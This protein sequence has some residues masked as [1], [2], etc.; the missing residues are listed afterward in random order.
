MQVPNNKRKIANR[1]LIVMVIGL[2]MIFLPMNLGLDG[3]DG[4]FALAV[5]GGLIAI[6]ALI[7][8][9]IYMRLA[10]EQDQLMSGANVLAHWKYTAEQWRMYAEI[11][12]RED[13]AAKT[14]LFWI[15]AGFALFFGIIFAVFGD[16]GGVY[17]LYVMLAL[18][19]IIAIVAKLSA[20][21]T[22]KRN[23]SRIGEV[24]LS[25]HSALINGQ[26]HVWNL[27]NARLTDVRL[28]EYE[29]MNML[30]VEYIV[31]QRNADAQYTARIPIPYGQEAE[32]EKV[33]NEIGKH[34]KN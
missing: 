23:L 3:M 5:F 12:Y 8:Y 30:E 25:E 33:A 15:V 18:I 21:T 14:M 17:V 31:P 6:T 2:L 34:K 19:A 10:R 22:Y 26:L 20:Q 1:S 13:K 16:E 9:F 24:L 4:G 11:D 7:T 27:L 29:Q 28:V 32:A